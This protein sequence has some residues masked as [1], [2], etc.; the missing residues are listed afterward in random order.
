MKGKMYLFMAVSAIIGTQ[1]SC[2]CE[3]EPKP[4]PPPVT[5]T[6]SVSKIGK[7][8]VVPDKDAG[9][10]LG[11]SRTLV[12]TADPDWAVYSAKSNNVIY[13]VPFM[14]TVYSFSINDINANQNV[15]VVSFKKNDLW[16]SRDKWYLWT[17]ENQYADNEPWYPQ[18][19]SLQEYTDYMIFTLDGKLSKYHSNGGIFGGPYPWS[20]VGETLSAIT[21]YTIK[22]LDGTKIILEY[23]IYGTDGGH[24]HERDTYYHSPKPL[25]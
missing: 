9:V 15:V 22:F 13:E 25:S 16:I 12:A 10:P 23:T 20:I 24:F 4:G 21:V 8:E 19:I 1:L 11:G 2:S 6:I 3:K 17:R 18:S 14:A 5:F 7:V